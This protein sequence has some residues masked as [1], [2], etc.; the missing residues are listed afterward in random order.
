MKQKI[1]EGLKLINL[2][3]LT[4]CILRKMYKKATH[5][6]LQKTQAPAI[7]LKSHIL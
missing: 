7:L 5:E 6:D 1:Y 3:T 2:K 4:V